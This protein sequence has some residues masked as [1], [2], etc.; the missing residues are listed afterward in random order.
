MGN[1]SLFLYISIAFPLIA[2]AVVASDKIRGAA[3]FLIFGLSAALFCGELNG[4]LKTL[5]D[6]P[7]QY[8]A[9]NISPIVEELVKAFPLIIYAFS[10]H[11]RRKFLIE[12]SICTGVGFAI[13]ENAFV[14]ANNIMSVSLP[15]A[16]VRGMG[17]GLM[18][19]L[20]GMAIGFG[21]SFIEREKNVAVLG[22]LGLLGAVT[23]Y[24][25]IYNK[26]ILSEYAMFAIIFPLLSIV[27]FV[28]I[29]KLREREQKQSNIEKT[30]NHKLK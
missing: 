2:V 19:A 13:L 11:P 5:T 30:K 18:H 4:Y 10:I 16:L 7:I 9:T 17:T 25:S 26:L 15:L 23:V 8:Y 21:L 3:L 24:H 22:T 27:P 1:L 28:V 14:F 29:L 12:Y 20:C 6:F